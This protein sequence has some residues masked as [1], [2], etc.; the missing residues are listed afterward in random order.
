MKKL[1]RRP[2][3]NNN[4]SSAPHIKGYCFYLCWR[5][6]GGIIGAFLWGLIRSIVQVNFN[7]MEMCLFCLLVIPGVIDYVLI[8]MNRVKPCNGRRFVTGLL[9]GAPLEE[10]GHRIIEWI[11]VG[12]CH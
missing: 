7:T 8:R 9:L 2:L 11:V 10:V 5:C 6:T 1:G 4:A 3:C 12:G